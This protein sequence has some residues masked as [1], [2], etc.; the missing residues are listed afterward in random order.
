MLIVGAAQ[1][2]IYGDAERAV[3]WEYDPVNNAIQRT[4]DLGLPTSGGKGKFGGG[5]GGG[6]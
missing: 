1:S 6:V 2:S 4:V 3:L 5:G